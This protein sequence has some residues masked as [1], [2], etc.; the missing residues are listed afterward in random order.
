MRILARW[1][2]AACAA[3]AAILAG[4]VLAQTAA[5]ER[6]VLD[7]V[8]AHAEFSIFARALEATRY[9]DVLRDG[10]P[11][12]VF[13]FTDQA[14]ARLPDPFADYLFSADGTKTLE[15][16]LAYHLIPGKATSSDMFGRVYEVPTLDG[17]MLTIEGQ[18]DFIRVNGSTVLR[19][20]IP[21]KNGVVH[22]LEYVIIPPH[23]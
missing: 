11:Y 1:R 14:F 13:A 17:Q 2:L 16:I 5:S 6:S 8:K 12:T 19:P 22:L 18:M 7:Q 9:A 4:P 21:A 10:G 3:L 20:D 23:F 15:Q